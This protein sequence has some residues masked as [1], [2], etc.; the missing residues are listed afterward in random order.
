DG[1]GLLD[2]QPRRPQLVAEVVAERLQ[3]RGEAT[4][5]HDGAAWQ[6]LAVRHSGT[7]LATLCVPG[8]WGSKG[9]SCVCC[10]AGR[11]SPPGDE[12]TGLTRVG[13]GSPGDPF[14]PRRPTSSAYR[15]RNDVSRV[16]N[17]S[18]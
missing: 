6:D 5:Q 1:V 18:R 3:M 13:Y 14:P 2:Q 17:A 7:H 8:I 15:N 10:A 12:T 11:P 4:V 16:R 9:S